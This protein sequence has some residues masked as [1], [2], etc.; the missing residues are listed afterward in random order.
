GFW[1]IGDTPLDV[2]CARAIGAKVVAV[3]TGIHSVDELAASQPDL[4]LADLSDA[5]PVLEVWKERWLQRNCHRNSCYA[6]GTKAIHL[7]LRGT[8]SEVEWL[9]SHHVVA[10][11]ALT[12]NSS[13]RKQAR[14][15][16]FPKFCGHDL[17]TIGQSSGELRYGR[18]ADPS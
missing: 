7:L 16:S 5:G 15:A 10:L 13:K 12:A 17:R 18:S 4:L 3:A 11:S 1:V 8:R 9:N 14:Q 2:R 6:R